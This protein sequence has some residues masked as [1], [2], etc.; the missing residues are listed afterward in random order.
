M[1]DLVGNP[2]DRFSD[3]AAHFREVVFPYF[4]EQLSVISHTQQ[5]F[6]STFKLNI[7]CTFNNLLAFFRRL[8]TLCGSLLL[9]NGTFIKR[10]E[11]VHLILQKKKP[12]ASHN[13]RRHSYSISA[14]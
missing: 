9:D 14:H 11:T 6:S 13:M 7:E 10:K 4:C 12:K 8:A 2:E 1:W 5:T 3:V